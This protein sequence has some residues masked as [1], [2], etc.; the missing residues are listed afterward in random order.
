LHVYSSSDT[1]IFRLQ[2]SDGTCNANPESTGVTWSCSSDARL[3]E[4]IRDAPQMLD[5]IMKIPI[6]QFEL[7]ATGVTKVGVIAQEIQQIMP[8]LVSKD[9]KGYL[10]VS[11]LSLY[12]LT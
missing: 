1:D 7:K 2:D 12:N 5:K 9:E 3:K 6:R 8:E 10:M 4:N 11:E